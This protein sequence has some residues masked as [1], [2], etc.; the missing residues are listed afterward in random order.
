MLANE[1][2]TTYYWIDAVCINQEDKDEKGHQ[3]YLMRD[4]FATAKQVIAF[5]GEPSDDSDEAI[6][7]IGVLRQ[8][9]EIN[10]FMKH[11]GLL[12]KINESLDLDMATLTLSGLPAQYPSPGWTAL[13]NLLKR[14]L[15]QRI[16]CIQEVAVAKQVELR[17]GNERTDWFALAYAMG[18]LARKGLATLSTVDENGYTQFEGC[19]NLSATFALKGIGKELR[20]MH[21]QHCLLFCN[22]FH[23]TL[24]E[25]KLY[26][27]LGIASN[28]TDLALRPD[29]TLT[30][31]DLYVK[32]TG[33]VLMRD[34]FLHML[35]LAGI[36]WPRQ[37]AD[38]PSWVPDFSCSRRSTILC[39]DDSLF[40]AAKPYAE[41]IEVN[42][43]VHLSIAVFF[44]DQVTE[45]M[46]QMPE[47]IRNSGMIEELQSRTEL[48]GWFKETKSWAQRT[49]KLPVTDDAE[50]IYWRTLLCD[51]PF[52]PGFASS[53]PTGGEYSE[54]FGALIELLEL[55]LLIKEDTEEAREALDAFHSILLEERENLVKI[56]LESRD[57]CLF[58]T[59]KGFIGLGPA[60]LKIGDDVCC[61]DGT[62]TPF[63]LRAT[64][65]DQTKYKP[66]RLIGEAFVHGLMNGEGRR[67]GDEERVTLI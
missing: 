62:I 27:V 24:P 34:R 13:K 3:I 20:T 46:P 49:M 44:V 2:E 61:I 67:L 10:S 32:V 60:G 40:R 9:I 15:F 29:Y 51:L 16:W 52:S 31:P 66:Y 48:L 5:V 58:C 14:P 39:L 19:L 42:Q 11:A 25:D 23:A 1:S 59:Q 55:S 21:L 33:Y 63:L 18:L 36:G 4:I 28:A 53:I 17:C 38:L 65:S 30:T 56:M 57:R 47:I 6:E 12:A 45:A 64:S 7:F 43:R 22:R 37:I 50:V 54:R 26:A 35:N 8:Q 41:F